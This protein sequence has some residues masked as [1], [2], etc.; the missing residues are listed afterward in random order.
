MFKLTLGLLLLALSFL[1]A[2]ATTARLP[3]HAVAL[4]YH[5][6]SD[7]T[8]A[9][10]SVTRG[11]FAE[12]LDYLENHH[13][14]VWPLTKIIDHLKNKR[15]VPDRVVAITFDDG[16][17]S[18]YDHAYPLLKSK[19]YPF[20]I[21]V[22]TDAIDKHF[23]SHMRW[24][25]LR[26][27]SAHGAS[28]EN[29]SVSHLHM[30]Q[31]QGNLSTAGHK[32]QLRREISHASERIK[33]EIGKASTLFAYPYGE[34]DTLTRELVAAAGLIGIG[35]HSGALGEDSDWLALPRY[36]I[37][38]NYANL[39]EFAIKLNTLPLNPVVI[40]EVDNPLTHDTDKPVLT[41]RLPAHISAAGLQCFGSG[42]DRL[43]VSLLNDNIVRVVPNSAIAVGRS[44][45]N[46]TVPAGDG[47]FYWYS[48]LWIRLKA[49]GS[50]LLD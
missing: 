37:A 48:K 33:A 43:K 25:Q 20:T 39:E 27:M 40:D 44:R 8:P 3:N 18:I 21:F 6:V 22:S 2:A 11:Q 32:V 26:E 28:I 19:Q 1:A 16:Y 13:Y 41:L 4:L 30:P 9:V 15:P 50:W 12:Q 23:G 29:H 36:A 42:Q 38:G 47:R 5:H 24:P 34:Y 10:T 49:D 45:Y 46:C 17:R 14:Q 7:D 31:R 35:Q